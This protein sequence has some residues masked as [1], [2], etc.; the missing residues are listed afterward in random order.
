MRTERIGLRKLLRQIAGRDGIGIEL[1]RDIADAVSEGDPL[2]A[3][4]KT[5]QIMQ[6][7]NRAGEL[8]WLGISERDG[9]K[10][11]KFRDPVSGNVYS[12][13]EPPTLKAEVLPSLPRGFVRKRDAA[14]IE[15]MFTSI[16]TCRSEDEL[17]GVLTRM[18]ATI[19]DMV[20]ADYSV[21]YFTDE[22]LKNVLEKTGDGQPQ[23]ESRFAPSL[24]DR[25][26]IDE[27]FCVH[28][29][30]LRRAAELSRF[31]NGGLFSSV[32]VV[33]LK[34][35]GKTYG[36]L[37]VWSRME[38]HFTADDLGFLS[39]LAML[40]AGMIRNAEHLE[41]LIFRDPLTHVYNRGFLEDQLEREIERYKRTNEPVGFLMVDVDNFKNVN[42][43]FGHPVGDLVLAA[44]GHVLEDKVRQIDIVSR[45]GGDEFGI[46]LPDT[47]GEHAYLTAERLREVVET[48]DFAADCPALGNRNITI[49]IGGAICPD[50][51]VTREGLIEKADRA[52]AEAERTGKN[53]A[54][55][56]G[57][58]PEEGSP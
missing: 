47:I 57:L 37:E 50:D 38:S 52:L 20:S 2:V 11:I 5:L 28:V 42:T 16:A 39:L 23:A 54:V 41:T 32:V 17:G 9:E 31:S 53:R 10:H 24:T 3:W 45:Y 6:G 8:V 49:S 40:A 30:D 22:S 48:H 19:R 44:I 43:D 14:K 29:P 27:G 36:L 25:W 4:E 33:P 46:I 18:L 13:K 51:A 55:F 1:R 15:S 56:H 7:L 21:V 12:L 26:V 58:A 35:R 34:S